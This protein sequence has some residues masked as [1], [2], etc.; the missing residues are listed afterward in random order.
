MN[1]EMEEVELDRV[2]T[3]MLGTLVDVGM[4]RD[5][6]GET[7][8]IEV[9]RLGILVSVEV[10]EDEVPVPGTVVVVGIDGNSVVKLGMFIV[11]ELESVPLGKPGGV[12]TEVGDGNPVGTF[13]T[14]VDDDAGV[15][16]LALEVVVV[17][18]PGVLIDD[19]AEGV[20]VVLDNGGKG[21]PV[22][23]VIDRLVPFEVN[24]VGVGRTGRLNDVVVDE[25]RV[26]VIDDDNDDDEED[27]ELKELEVGKLE[28]E[29]LEMERLGMEG[30][31]V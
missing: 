6:G 19:E 13:T 26:V 12:D 27:T 16:T 29:G 23:V 11:V 4:D 10:N 24:K 17:L 21:G 30:L 8:G 1:V 2:V 31:G 7:D 22:G 25:D 18:E 28:V 15:D 9:V 5:V 3:D 20:C 14:E